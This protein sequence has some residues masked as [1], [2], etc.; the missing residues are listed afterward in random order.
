MSLSRAPE[1]DRIADQIRRACYG[2]AWH[3][4]SV[5][6][7]LDGVTPEIASRRPL[8]DI[9]SIWE[10]TLHITAWVDIVRRRIS[11]ETVTVTPELNF[12]QVDEVS[13]HSWAQALD[14]LERRHRELLDYI[15][16]IAP[17]RLDEP[18][19]A[20]GSSVYVQL[21]GV[22]QHDTYHAGQ[23]VLLKKLILT[24]NA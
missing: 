9:H 15:P 19:M 20:V 24:R 2:E 5:K 1:L 21:H 8:Q 18:G 6:E 22:A 23:I 16:T 11:G 14:K 17:S 13:D 3:G 10:L 12:P 7:A 4:P